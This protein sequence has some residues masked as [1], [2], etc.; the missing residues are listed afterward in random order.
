MKNIYFHS[1]ASTGG[2]TYANAIGR[3]EPI[4]KVVEITDGF[5][6]VVVGDTNILMK[7]GDESC[8][9]KGHNL[10]GLLEK[11]KLPDKYI[12]ML[13]DPKDRTIS[14]FFWHR[15]L[16]ERIG[17]FKYSYIED[18]DSFFDHVNNSSHLNFYIHHLS[19]INFDN[20]KT[21]NINECS[22]IPNNDALQQARKSL[23]SKFLD[24]G[25]TEEFDRSI[26]KLSEKLCLT[27][28]ANWIESRH[29]ATPGRPSFFE[30]PL[31]IQ[32]MIHEKTREDNELYLEQK[33]KF[34]DSTSNY[35][36]KKFFIDYA[37]WNNR[38]DP[39]N[40]SNDIYNYDL[41]KKS[42][43]NLKFDLKIICVGIGGAFHDLLN[44]QAFDNFKI[45]SLYDS[46]KF[47]YNVAGLQVQSIDKIDLNDIDVILI[48]STRF[49]KELRNTVLYMRNKYSSSALII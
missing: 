9:F 14:D 45:I 42:L 46:F 8:I 19:H 13:R 6:G 10:Y 47:G 28:V 30:L 44:A 12:T 3:S 21:F 41:Y 36:S 16:E 18:I 32:K 33:E 24:I 34:E 26:F 38:S 37:N 7:Y 31:K 48:T 29:E 5:P 20:K 49:Y 39:I 25:I 11:A 15:R 23:D 1:L 40:A 17:C 27:K 2:N 4:R 22:R 35:I 43:S